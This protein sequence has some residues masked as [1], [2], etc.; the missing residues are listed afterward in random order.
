MHAR[1][2]FDRLNLIS[3]ADRDWL[4]CGIRPYRRDKN[5]HSSETAQIERARGMRAV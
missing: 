3:A 5:L 1:E 4:Q 2:L